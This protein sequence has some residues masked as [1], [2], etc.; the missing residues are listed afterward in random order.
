[1]QVVDGNT[2][3]CENP[4]HQQVFLH[5][6]GLAWP[7]SDWDWNLDLSGFQRVSA[8]LNCPLLLLPP[9]ILIGLLPLL[10]GV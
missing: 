10:W 3:A 4:D 1:M 5:T 9:S 2:E 8:T 6:W 7:V